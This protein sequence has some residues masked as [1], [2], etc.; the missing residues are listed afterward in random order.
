MHDKKVKLKFVNK[1]LDITKRHVIEYFDVIDIPNNNKVGYIRYTINRDDKTIFIHNIEMCPK[2]EGYGSATINLLKEEYPNYLLSGNILYPG[3]C[4]F[5]KTFDSKLI[6][7]TG[8][9]P[10][11]WFEFYL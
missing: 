5:W 11:L 8:N 9:E 6:N 10:D 3:A 4:E 2:R 7:C 1:E